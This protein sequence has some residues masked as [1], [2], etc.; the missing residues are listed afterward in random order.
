[1]I[2]ASPT[3][4]ERAPICSV[5]GGRLIGIDADPDALRFARDLLKDYDNQFLAFHDRFGNIRPVLS[6]LGISSVQGIL[7]DLGV[8]SYQLDAPSKGFSFR[9]NERL[10]MRMDRAQPRDAIL[11][12]NT[13]EVDELERI[14]REYGEEHH[15]RK[16]AKRIAQERTRRKIEFSGELAALVEDVVGKRYLTKSLARV[17]Q[18]IRIEV[19]DELHQLEQGLQASLQFLASGGRLVV[20]SYHSLEDRIVKQFFRRAS[21]TSIPSGTKLI[22]DTPVEPLLKVLTKSSVKPSQQEQA[23][24]PRSRSARLRAAEKIAK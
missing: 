15:A 19:N 23:G 12:L 20:I 18:A 4:R 14:F 21:A 1:M 8:S 13:L 6:G 16:I 11:V 2:S 7:F 22:P 3:R 9:R 10:D 5:A 24:N 17:F